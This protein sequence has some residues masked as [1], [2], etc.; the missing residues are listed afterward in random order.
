MSGL[1]LVG[2]C[3]SSP[4]THRHVCNLP[5]I[6]HD[7]LC[8]PGGEPDDGRVGVLIMRGEGVGRWKMIDLFLKAETGAH[9]NIPEVELYWATSVTIEPKQPSEGEGVVGS[10]AVDGE[11]LRLSRISHLRITQL[12]ACVQRS[13][14]VQ[15]TVGK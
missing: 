9:V 13:V 10:I 15:S 6:S 3:P 2:S 1:T 11:P 4:P 7:A 5:W 14:R 12:A 8:A